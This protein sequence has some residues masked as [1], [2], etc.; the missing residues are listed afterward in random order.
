[1]D[2]EDFISLKPAAQTA[3]ETPK[4]ARVSSEGDSRTPDVPWQPKVIKVVSEEAR[5]KPFTQLHNELIHFLDFITISKSEREK[6]SKVKCLFWVLN[7]AF[8]IL[9]L[10]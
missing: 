2:Q 3:S 1:M 9:V 8:F 5:Y 10:C 7:G 6:R 4:S